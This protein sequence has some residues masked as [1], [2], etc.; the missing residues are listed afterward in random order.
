MLLAS[1]GLGS[2]LVG[3]SC[4]E[5]MPANRTGLLRQ[6]VDGQMRARPPFFGDKSRLQGVRFWCSRVQ[7]FS[8]KVAD[9]KVATLPESSEV[10]GVPGFVRAPLPLQTS[11]ETPS[12]SPLLFVVFVVMCC[13]FF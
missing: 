3:S 2:G 5:F 7:G 1:V 12:S 11:E 9:G 8:T 10:G 6:S 4:L 13:R